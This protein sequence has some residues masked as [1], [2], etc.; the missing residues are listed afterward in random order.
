MVRGL[1][2][3]YELVRGILTSLTPRPDHVRQDTIEAQGPRR[4]LSVVL[5]EVDVDPLPIQG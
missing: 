5:F 2:R 3:G 1:R 4:F